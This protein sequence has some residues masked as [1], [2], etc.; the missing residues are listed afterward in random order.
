MCH[1]QTRATAVNVYLRVHASDDGL[2]QDDEATQK[3]RDALLRDVNASSPGGVRGPER[4]AR[5]EEVAE[6]LR[7]HFPEKLT[8][9]QKKMDDEEVRAFVPPRAGAK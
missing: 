6:A 3:A 1:R 4:W 9:E 8:A 7:E 5:V 2:P